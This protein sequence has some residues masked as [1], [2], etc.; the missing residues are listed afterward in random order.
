L[1]PDQLRRLT[2]LRAYTAAIRQHL[3][4]LAGE[5]DPPSLDIELNEIVVS[6]K[7]QRLAR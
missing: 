6:P 1:L 2:I 5:I 3:E 7:V 4:P